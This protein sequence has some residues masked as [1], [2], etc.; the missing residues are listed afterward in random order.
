MRRCVLLSYNPDTKLVD[1]RH[2][3]I[4]VIPVGVSKGVKKFIQGKVPNL[5]KC[6]DISDF[7]TK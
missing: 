1:F 3:S 5:S 2:Y 7:L 4:K 6:N